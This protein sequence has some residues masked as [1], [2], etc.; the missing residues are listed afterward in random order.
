MDLVLVDGG[1]ERRIEHHRTGVLLIVVG[2]VVI[3]I[4]VGV[5]RVGTPVVGVVGAVV[6]VPRTGAD[7]GVDL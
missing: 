7:H 1:V 3:V 2:R 4:V 5:R 6:G